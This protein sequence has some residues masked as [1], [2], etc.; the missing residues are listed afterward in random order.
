MVALSE[1]LIVSGCFILAGVEGYMKRMIFLS[2]PILL[3]SGVLL[4]FWLFYGARQAPSWQPVL[5]DYI[6]YKE[7]ALAAPVIVQAIDHATKPW[8]LVKDKSLIVFG[9]SVYYRTDVSLDQSQAGAR[10]LPDP[11]VDVYCI[12]L[13][14]QG[15]PVAGAPASQLVFAGLHRDI[16]NADWVIHEVEGP[17]SSPAALQTISRVGC[18]AA[19]LQIETP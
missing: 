2:I 4:G 11:P 1:F 7:Q 14:V 9:N 6:A 16:Y 15:P 3:T 10:P 13:K 5:D 12:L 17:P 18:D 19:R 8:D